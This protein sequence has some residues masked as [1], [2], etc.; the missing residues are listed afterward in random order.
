MSERTSK[1]RQEILEIPDAVD[2][3]L[4][5]GAPGIQ[6]A[7]QMVKQAD[8]QFLITVARGS[9]DHA[10]TYLKYASELFL[11]LPVASVGPSVNSIYGVDLQAKGALCLSISQSGQSPDIVGMTRS[12]R[13]SGGVTVAITN[14]TNSRLSEVTDAVLPLHAGPELSVAATK[15]FVT[16]L[17]SGLWLLAEVKGDNEL[18]GAIHALPDCLARA[19]TCDWSAAAETITGRSLFTLGRGPSYAMS[20]EAALKIKETCQIHAESYSAAEVLHGP[21]SIVEDG[22]PTIVFAARDAAEQTTA[23]AADALAGK[24]ATVFAATDKVTRAQVLPV[25]RTGHWLTDPVATITSFYSMVEAVAGAR[26]IDP[27]A[28][29]HLKKVTET[30]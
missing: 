9:S 18:I 8:P 14:N 13:S 3:L 20:N 11:N 7:A 16:S 17:V 28:P 6:A 26:G 4:S 25:A 1:M 30:V 19:A 10:C 23:E 22:F 21:V 27:D 15:T 2:R 12:L 24:G 5:Q 29:R